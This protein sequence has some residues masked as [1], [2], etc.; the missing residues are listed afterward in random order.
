MDWPAVPLG[1][2]EEGGGGGRGM[3][4]AEREDVT[5]IAVETSEVLAVGTATE[6]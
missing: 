6:F 4:D 2:R 1:R 5:A 3:G